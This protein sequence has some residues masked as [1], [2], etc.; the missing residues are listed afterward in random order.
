LYGTAHNGAASSTLP[1]VP[2]LPQTAPRVVVGTA[3]DHH[4]V[5]EL[6]QRAFRAPSPDAFSVSLEDPAYEPCDRL[7]VRRGERLVGHALLSPRQMLWGSQQAT[8]TGVSWL[9]TMPEYRGRGIGRHLLQAAEEQLRADGARA[10]VLITRIPHFF[11]R[12]GWVLCGRV[13]RYAAGARALLAH[14]SRENTHRQGPCIRPWRQVELPALVRLYEANLAP[15]MLARSE[16]TWRWLIARRAFDQIYVATDSPGRSQLEDNGAHLAGYVITKGNDVLELMAEPTR[17]QVARQLL[18]R[19]C[20]D[21]IEMNCHHLGLFAPPGDALTDLCLAVGG[22]RQGRHEG[23][24]RADC[25]CLMVKLPDPLAA[26][27]W[28]APQLH[29]R[30]EAASLPRPCELGLAFDD[31]RVNVLLTRR[32]VKLTSGRSSRGYLR[33]S[34]SDFTRLLWGAIDV[35]RSLDGGRMTASSRAAARAAAVLFPKL[36][37]WRAPLDDLME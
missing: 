12:A 29:Q 34:R 31:V 7:L 10:G 21:A 30:A 4:A 18:E 24:A 5:F 9:A 22:H 1:A 35:E 20:S 32:G 16:E 3:S 11:G 26:L 25:D 37:L 8:V 33:L 14:L 23:L 2:P 17:P 28:L 15:G 6:L 19:V 36:P 13:S 27:E